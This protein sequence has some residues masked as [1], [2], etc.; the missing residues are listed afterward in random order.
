MCKCAPGKMI[1]FCHERGCEP[2]NRDEFYPGGHLPEA[3][4]ESAI[5]FGLV[6]YAPI[7]TVITYSQIDAAL[8]RA[9][10]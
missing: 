2:A 1:P 10:M 4:K 6:R 9:G 7:T 8:K 3:D 5:L